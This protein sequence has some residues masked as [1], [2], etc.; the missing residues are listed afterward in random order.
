MEFDDLS[1]TYYVFLKW[2]DGEV[3]EHH[4]NVVY[5]NCPQQLALFYVGIFEL[6]GPE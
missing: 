6:V 1:N 3:T 2:P 4:K 5:E